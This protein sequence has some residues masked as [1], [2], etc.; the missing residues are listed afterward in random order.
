LTYLF[1]L[2]HHNHWLFLS[3][4]P[5]NSLLAPPHSLGNFK[6]FPWSLYSSH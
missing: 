1:N 2:Y 6:W 3:N 4:R 5:S